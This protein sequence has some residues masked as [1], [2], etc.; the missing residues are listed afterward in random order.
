MPIL[1]KPSFSFALFL[2]EPATTPPHNDEERGELLAL[3]GSPLWHPSGHLAAGRFHNIW[4]W[5]GD[6]YY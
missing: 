3:L 4:N 5:G 2:N 6:I 1:L